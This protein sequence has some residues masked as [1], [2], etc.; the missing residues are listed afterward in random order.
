[1][2]CRHDLAVNTC[3][4]CYPLTGSVEPEPE[5]HYEENLEGPGAVPTDPTDR[6]PYPEETGPNTLTEKITIEVE[7][8]TL[9]DRCGFNYLD[10]SHP[11]LNHTCQWLAIDDV[12]TS[13]R[14]TLFKTPLTS[15][16]TNRLVI[17]RCDICSLLLPSP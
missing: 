15:S 8:K 5:E 9:G 4:R 12:G 10:F 7:R 6:T 17:Y 16:P 14:C 13:H 3:K 1:M 11:Q 2:S